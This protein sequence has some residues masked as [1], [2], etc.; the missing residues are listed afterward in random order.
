MQ[1]KVTLGKYS[2]WIRGRQG[3]VSFL[4]KRR[5][6]S[7]LNNFA[8]IGLINCK[9]FLWILRLLYDAQNLSKVTNTIQ[10]NSL[11]KT[12]SFLKIHKHAFWFLKLKKNIQLNNRI[13]SFILSQELKFW[14]PA[15]L[16]EG[17]TDP[18]KV[19]LYKIYYVYNTFLI[20]IVDKHF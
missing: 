10:K 18:G 16:A 5:R 6:D 11:H 20:L 1:R 19:F 9:T 17:T 13:F 7:D 2:N 12:R 3:R 8:I 4:L 14:A 15:N